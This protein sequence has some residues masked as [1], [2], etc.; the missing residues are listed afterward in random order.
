MYDGAG[1]LALILLSTLLLSADLS[2]VWRIYPCVVLSRRREVLRKKRR[3]IREQAANDLASSYEMNVFD[4]NERSHIGIH[5]IKQRQ[6][7][8]YLR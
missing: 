5:L 2:A 3:T 6:S 4:L 1:S 7:R 8:S